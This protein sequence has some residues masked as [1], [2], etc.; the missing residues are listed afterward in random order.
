MQRNT[1]QKHT[2]GADSKA[3]ERNRQ[4]SKELAKTYDPKGIEER[5]YQ[6]WET[7][8]YFRAKA[9]KSKKPF[10]LVGG[11]AVISGAYGACAGQYDAGYF[12]PV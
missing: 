5:L 3:K 12:D 11:G 9:D 4:M 8:G 6:K 7:N 2:A 10:I 1:A